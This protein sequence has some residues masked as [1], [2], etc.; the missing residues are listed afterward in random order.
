MIIHLEKM[1]YNDNQMSDMMNRFPTF[2]LSYELGQ[3]K[4]VSSDYN[5][6]FAIP[7][8][9][10]AFIWFTFHLDQNVCLLL[11]TNRD[12]KVIKMTELSTNIPLDLAK[13]TLLYGCIYEH[14]DG[15]THFFVIEDIFYAK[16]VPFTKQTMTEKM[17]CLHSLYNQYAQTFMGLSTPIALPVM[18][19]VNEVSNTIPEKWSNQISYTIHHLQYR[20][21]HTIVPFINYNR[22]MNMEHTVTNQPKASLRKEEDDLRWMF[23][24]PPLPFFSYF[25]PQYKMNSIFEC[26]AD[27][28]ND[29]YHLYA[30]G[31]VKQQPES[32]KTNRTYCGIAYIPNCEISV[33]MNGLFRHIKENRNLDLLEE[34]DDED[35]FLDQRVDRFVDLK[36][37]LYLECTF[38]L[39]FKK[40]IPIRQVN[41][42]NGQTVP[43]VP[44]MRL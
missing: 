24:A 20:S 30:F 1:I 7:Y 10:K 11:E 32:Y 35:E 15:D 3:H 12:K 42:R 38:H 23:F 26:R 13:G 19:P 18:W 6:C 39:K 36:K 31:R 16:G 33:F 17:G 29:V 37:T 25:K 14:T 28:Q 43:L 44:I 4:K 9:K 21:L 27:L 5:I 22:T 8:G 40:W 41:P 2:E 34:S